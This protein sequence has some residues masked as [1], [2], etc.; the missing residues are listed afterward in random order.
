MEMGSMSR[1][2]IVNGF[3][4]KDNLFY[5]YNLVYLESAKILYV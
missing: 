3:P 1:D 2:E 4:S 5:F